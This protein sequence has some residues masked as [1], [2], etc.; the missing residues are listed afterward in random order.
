VNGP[1]D[2]SSYLSGGE[3]LLDLEVVISK[4]RSTASWDII[5]SNQLGDTLVT[6]YDNSRNQFFVDR[7]GAGVTSFS[8]KFSGKRY[9][10]R[11][12]RNPQMPVKILL[13][14][15]SVEIFHDKGEVVFTERFFADQPFTKMSI[16][17]RDEAV[18]VEGMVYQLE[19]IWK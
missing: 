7:S 2:F 6:G 14:R 3:Y 18:L 1:G 8:D 11:M 17:S 19:S 10:Q 4:V 5:F 9:A 16:V 15:S 13:D 12:S